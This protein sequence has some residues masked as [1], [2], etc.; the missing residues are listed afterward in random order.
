MV[1]NTW[2][3]KCFSCNLKYIFL[4]CNHLHSFAIALE[5]IIDTRHLISHF[6]CIRVN[7]ACENF[8]L[9]QKHTF[10]QE[11][12]TS[13]ILQTSSRDRVRASPSAAKPVKPPAS[14][15]CIDT[16]TAHGPGIFSGTFSGNV[17]SPAVFVIWVLLLSGC[18]KG[19]F[20]S[21]PNVSLL[22]ALT[23]CSTSL[24]SGVPWVGLLQTTPV[25]AFTGWQCLRRDARLCAVYRCHRWVYMRP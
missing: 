9:M 4:N 20:M 8:G 15:A 7:D 6:I 17:L 14:G 19:C 25:S 3:T 24:R 16:F 2:F 11:K 22:W 12:H 23:S 10:A 21:V 18:T 5:S 1:E 13:I